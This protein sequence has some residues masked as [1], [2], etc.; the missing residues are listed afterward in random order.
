MNTN[1]ITITMFLVGVM[2]A[3]DVEATPTNVDRVVSVV[4]DM[5][6]THSDT[7]LEAAID[8]VMPSSTHPFSTPSLIERTEEMRL[9]LQVVNG[10]RSYQPTEAEIASRTAQ[11]RIAWGDSWER[12]VAQFGLDEISLH[13]LVRTRLTIERYVTRNTSGFSEAQWAD[14]VDRRRSQTTIRRVAPQSVNNST[15]AQ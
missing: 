14:W 12:F 11:M 4:G 2:V 3:Q 13:Q 10:V 1:L 7:Q 9:V 8:M 6:I 5:V 15:T